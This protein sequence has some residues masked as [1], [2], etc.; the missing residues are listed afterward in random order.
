MAPEPKFSRDDLV[1]TVKAL[2]SP[3]SE[4]EVTENV[5]TVP[6]S[7]LKVLKT[8]EVKV[9]TQETNVPPHHLV[10]TGE[11]IKTN[12]GIKAEPSSELKVVAPEMKS[13]P[14][15]L[16]KTIEAVATNEGIATVHWKRNYFLPTVQK[17][18]NRSILLMR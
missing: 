1:E 2:K 7:D 15:Q 18:L 9:V 11:G 3:V 12:E 5:T 10:E 4:I 6:P 17:M 16:V 13:T 14:A 8:P